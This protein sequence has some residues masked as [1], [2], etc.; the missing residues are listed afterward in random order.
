MT[1]FTACVL[2]TVVFW[3][4]RLTQ[5]LK[6]KSGEVAVWGSLG[7]CT[8]GPEYQYATVGDFDEDGHLDANPEY[9]YGFTDIPEMQIIDANYVQVT[10]VGKIRRGGVA[11]SQGTKG[12]RYG[13]SCSYLVPTWT[14]ADE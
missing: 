11:L 1:T 12:G 4:T 6:V 10:G 3:A 5:S 14:L 2:M 13:G 9:S 8:I 7:Y